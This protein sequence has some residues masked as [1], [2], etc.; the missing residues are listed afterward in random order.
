MVHVLEMITAIVKLIYVG[1]I[2]GYFK[3]ESDACRI[4]WKCPSCSVTC[5]SDITLTFK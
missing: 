5:P 2:I 1:Y 4:V 3:Y